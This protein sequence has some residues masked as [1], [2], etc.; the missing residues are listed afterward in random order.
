VT[1]RRAKQ[2]W[3]THQRPPDRKHLLFS[4]AE[5]TPRLAIPFLQAREQLMNPLQ[6]L[7]E[8]FPILWKDG[9]H[10]EVFPHGQIGKNAPSL[11]HLADTQSNNF[12]RIGLVQRNIII[13]DCAAFRAE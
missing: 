6:I 4:T 1:A 12:V 7:V 10:F 11:R 13:N 8:R 3:I 9:A 5:S 2:F